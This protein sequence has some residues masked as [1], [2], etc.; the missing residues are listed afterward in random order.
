MATVQKR[1]KSS[2]WLLSRNE[3]FAL[4]IIIIRQKRSK[5]LQL[6]SE[7]FKQLASRQT[8]GDIISA[9][10]KWLDCGFTNSNNKKFRTG[11]QCELESALQIWFGNV[12]SQNAA[13]ALAVLNFACAYYA[14]NTGIQHLQCYDWRIL[15]SLTILCNRLLDWLALFMLPPRPSPE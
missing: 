1:I 9:K 7:H 2:A 8:L 3:K 14:C 15:Y 6:F 12:H 11:K 4:I 5:V 13:V 10:L